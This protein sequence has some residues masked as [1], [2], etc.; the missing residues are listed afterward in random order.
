MN[1]VKSIIQKWNTLIEDL[2]MGVL[3]ENLFTEAVKETYYHF[4][5]FCTPSCLSPERDFTN[6]EEELFKIIFSYR[7]L[8]EYVPTE[9]ECLYEATRIVADRLEFADYREAPFLLKHIPAKKGGVLFEYNVDTGDLSNII[10][11]VHY[12][13]I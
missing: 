5:G 1:N 8:H 9:M 11:N 7:Y 13:I 6:D 10:E 4:K 3:N 2:K 12:L